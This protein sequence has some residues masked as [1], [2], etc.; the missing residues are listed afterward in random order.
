MEWKQ[1]KITHD[2]LKEGKYRNVSTTLLEAK[3]LYND[4]GSINEEASYSSEWLKKQQKK[5]TKQQQKDVK[6]ERNK[7]KNNKEESD[8]QESSGGNKLLGCLSKILLFP[9]TAIGWIIKH[10]ADVP[11][12]SW[13]IGLGTITLVLPIW[14]II[15]LPFAIIKNIYNLICYIIKSPIYALT[16]P[17]RKIL[18]SSYDEGPEEPIASFPKYSFMEF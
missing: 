11:D 2:E 7:K 10:F 15:K 4:D 16:Y 17:I 1:I 12:P 14:W 6:S 9:F 5:E 13:A 3:V 18:S 8:A